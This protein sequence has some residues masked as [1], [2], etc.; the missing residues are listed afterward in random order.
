MVVQSLN[1]YS[2][3]YGTLRTFRVADDN[4]LVGI[5]ALDFFLPD[6]AVIT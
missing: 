1:L 6:K 2:L 4:I 5:Y 3:Y